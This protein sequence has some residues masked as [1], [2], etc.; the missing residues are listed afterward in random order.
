MKNLV[1]YSERVNLTGE[2]DED[3][4]RLLGQRVIERAEQDKKSMKEWADCVDEGLELCKP[5]FKPKSEPWD[6]AAN[7]KAMILAEASNDFGNRCK[8]ELMRERNLVKTGVLGATTL[9]NVIEQTST[10][11]SIVREQMEKITAQLEQLQQAGGELEPQQQQMLE[12][13]QTLIT[14]NDQKI[15]DSRNDLREKQH[16]A[17]RVS[18]AMNWAV[19]NRMEHWRTDHSDM[20]YR[21][22]LH[23]TSFKKTFYDPS[24]NCYRSTVVLYPDFIVNQ[25]TVHLDTAR[26]F[27]HII[28]VDKSTSDHR[29]DKGIWREVDL[30]PD[31]EEPETGSNEQEEVDKTE[32]NPN[33]FYE[34]LCWYD[35]DDDGTEEPYI[36]TVHVGSQNVVR[37]VARYDIDTIMVRIKDRPGYGSRPSI[38]PLNEAKR[39]LATMIIEDAQESGI[40]PILPEQEDFDGF[41]LAVVKPKS[42]LTKYGFMKSLDGTFLDVGLFH[43][44]GPLTAGINKV[45]NDLLNAGTLANLQGGITARGFRKTPGPFRIKPG[46]FT[47]T[48][49]PAEQ[50]ASSMLPLPFKEPS[51]TLMAL[52]QGMEEQGRGF[53]ANVDAAI[54]SNTAPT[55]ALAMVQESLTTQTAKVSAVVDSMTQEFKVLYQLMRDYFDPDDYRELIGD[56]D[57][58]LNA[59]FNVRGLSV[60]CGANPEMSSKM[61]RMILAQAELEQVPL[62]LQAGGNPIPIIK[63][64]FRRIGS[65]NVDEIFPNEAEMSPEEK[66]QMQAMLQQQEMANQMAQQQ[67]EMVT[68]QTELLKSEQERKDFEAQIKARETLAKMDKMLEEVQEIKAKTLWTL[69][70]AESEEVKNQIDVYTARSNE[71]DKAEA[72]LSRDEQP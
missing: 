63:S 6:G 34:Q 40:E 10:E 21:L 1:E 22:P 49:I 71:L 31:G 48:E 36:V 4:L 43:Q 37:M 23:G 45:S 72:A 70:R 3:E 2:L 12:Q 7:Y 33:R 44:L 35:I 15:I 62:V 54:Q 66:Q 9:K 25:N 20:L 14:E 32:D 5:E 56:D 50:L 59:D 55:T 19:D 26:A 17:D 64:Y 42:M 11:T 24:D 53:V 13:L 47:N 69:E 39:K 30:F 61:Q 57:A 46:E 68:L 58:D 29:M 41:E 27:T 60:V 38:Y 67:L 28:D 52:R 18:E 8:I 65:E 51:A 16:R